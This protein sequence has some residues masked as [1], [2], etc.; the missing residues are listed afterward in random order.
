MMKKI[1]LG[2]AILASLFASGAQAY[3]N[4]SGGVVTTDSTTELQAWAS[5]EFNSGLFDNI[6]ANFASFGNLGRSSGLTITPVTVTAT[7]GLAADTFFLALFGGQTSGLTT[8]INFT[9]TSFGS[10]Q[11]AFVLTQDAFGVPLGTQIT[12]DVVSDPPRTL[13]GA[14]YVTPGPI[15]GAGLPLLAA[16]AGFALWRRRKDAE[17][18]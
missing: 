13:S 10:G 11:S 7:G 12:H 5:S 2:G 17:A 9:E 1:L 15:A 4:Y 16:L 3:T 8:W 18:F 14:F 6:L